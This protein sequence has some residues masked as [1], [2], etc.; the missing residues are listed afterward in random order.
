MPTTMVTEDVRLHIP[1]FD[2]II[3][4]IK[5]SSLSL[6][7]RDLDIAHLPCP[8][9]SI[10]LVPEYVDKKDI[11]YTLMSINKVLNASQ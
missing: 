9:F 10:M 8:K 5:V 3:G 4:P 1:T 11:N 7:K 6:I 2:Y